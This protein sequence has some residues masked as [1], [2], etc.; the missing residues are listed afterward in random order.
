LALALVAGA[1]AALLVGPNINITK[2]AENDSETFISLDPTNP[3]RLF[4]T[5]TDGTNVFR[6]SSDGGV[7]WNNSD[8]SGVLGGSSSGD[9][10]S[11]WDNFGNLFVTYFAGASDHTVLALSTD[12]G[13]TFSLL[14]DTGATYDQ[15]NVAVGPGEVWFDYANPKRTA[16]GAAVTGL[17]AV[18][19]FS[20]PQTMNGSQGSFGD[21]AIGPAGQVLDVYQTQTGIGPSTIFANLNPTGVGGTFGAQITIGTTN[22]GD[23]APIPPQPDR[24]IDAETGLAWDR[25]GGP[26]N[27]RVYLVYT[28]RPSTSSADTDI[29]VRFSDDNGTTWSSPVRVNDDP[30]GNG[31]SQWFPRIALDQTTGNIAVSFYDCRNSPGNNTVQLWATVS[32]D[33]GLTFLPNIK[34]STGTTNGTVA[35]LGGFDLGDYNGLTFHGGV[36]YPSWADNSNSTGDNPDGTLRNTD[37]YTARVTVDFPPLVITPTS[38][39]ITVSTATLGGNVTSTG[40]SA[41]IERGVV[42]SITS[43]NANP[44]IG[45]PGVTKVTAGGTLGVFTVGAT[46]LAPATNYSFKAYAINS[47]GTTY[48]TPTSTFTTLAGTPTVTTPTQ[49]AI[50]DNTATLGGN[51]TSDGGAT[52]TERGVVYSDTTVNPDPFIGGPGVTKVTTGGTLGVFTVGVTGLLQITGY[53]FKAYATNGVGTAY[54]TPAS[55]FTTTVHWTV[56][57][58][59]QPSAG[60]STTG[61]GSYLDGTTVTVTA[62]PKPGYGFLSWTEPGVQGV[63]STSFTYTFAVRKHRMLFANFAPLYTISASTPGNGTVSGSGIYTGT[64]SVTVKAM[65]GQGFSLLNWTENGTPVST[66]PNY[67]FAIGSNRTLVANYTPNASN[68]YLTSL[69]P[70]IGQLSPV[71]TNTTT[72]YTLGVNKTTLGISFTPFTMQSGATVTINGTPVASGLP[73]GAVPLAIGANPITV[74]VTS[75]DQTVTID[76]T[77]TVTRSTKNTPMDVNGDGFD[78][79]V[80]QNTAGQIYA[81]DMNGSGGIASS[82]FISTLVIPDWKLCARAELDGDGVNDILFQNSSGQIIVWYMKADGS[83]K[84]ATYLNTA[85]LGSW[86]LVGAADMN[87]DGNADLVF[88]NAS[89]QIGVWYMDGTGKVT[90]AVVLSYDY[91]ADYKIVGLADMNN[92]GNTDIVFQNN[93]GQIIVWYMDGAGHHPNYAYLYSETKLGDWRVVNIADMN[94]DGNADLVFQNTAGQIFAWYMDGNG[95]ISTYGYLNKVYLGDWRLR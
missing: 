42:Y 65:P 35:A 75:Q 5:S 13:A 54:T 76:Y 32:M 28:D 61:N 71:F 72:A 4:A 25:S 41:I 84:S 15:P 64:T 21:L 47:T 16:Q 24:D 59:A 93:I 52:I 83:I 27:G 26:H 73:S 31:K 33:G 53:S 30:V 20:A 37:L 60:G 39:G 51:V 29:Y 57:T 18:G 22:V 86:K 40:G 66:S 63:V 48:T 3:L 8:I 67:T 6:Y 81:W 7:T 12:G 2:S 50:A 44:L 80:F 82:G 92:D 11:A 38:A 74:R 87:N 9:Q 79:L 94:G 45:G 56:S 14:V 10:Q 91:L 77:V 78:D 34:V 49:T 62:T 36:F 90:S 17:G 68:A 70:G 23:F 69:V 46:G 1:D 85:Y 95:S 88:Q 89:T 43:V 19:A 58:S 55:T